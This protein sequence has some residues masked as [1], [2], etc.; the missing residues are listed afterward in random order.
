MKQVPAIWLVMTSL[1]E[2]GIS[3]LHIPKTFPILEELSATPQLVPTE[4]QGISTPGVL[5]QRSAHDWPL[6][7]FQRSST[8]AGIGVGVGG[9]GV[10]VGGGSGWQAPFRQP[11]GQV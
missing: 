4:T 5:R 2:L 6:A 8:R 10:G 9:M 1:Q 3:L 7:M 11:K